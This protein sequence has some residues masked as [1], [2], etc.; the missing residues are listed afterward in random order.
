MTDSDFWINLICCQFM[1]Y[2]LYDWHSCLSQF[3]LWS[4][5]DILPIWVTSC[6]GKFNLGSICDISH[7]LNFHVW[8]KSID[9]QFMIYFP[10][11]PFSSLGH[12]NLGTIYD[13]HKLLIKDF[14]VR[15]DSISCQFMIFYTYNWLLCPYSIHVIFMF[16]FHSI[17]IPYLISYLGQFNLGS[18]YDILPILLTFMSWP[19]QFKVY[20]ICYSYYWLSCLG[21]FN[22]ASLYDIL[23]IWLTSMSGS[24]QF[25]FSL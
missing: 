15:T 23:P 10:Y 7:M 18:V 13:I 3:N 8:F 17:Q 11:D 6:L 21:Q 12:L 24:I 2:L 19:I 25:K 1:M 9:S 22:L 5:Y 14:H 20:F 16:L 4:I